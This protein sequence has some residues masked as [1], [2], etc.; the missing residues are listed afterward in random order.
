[1]TLFQILP[2]AAGCL[3]LI[4]TIWVLLKPAKD[5]RRG[6]A[7]PSLLFILFTGFSIYTVATDG[8][9]GFW[10]NHTVNA[11]GNQVWFD[12]LLAIGIAWTLILP[13]A[14]AQNMRLPLWLAFICCTG[15]VGV[16]AMLSR[17]FWLENEATS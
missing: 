2:I 17:L 1:M 7:I 5:G 15:C 12:L 10:N 4:I 11:S 14:R 3:F 16:L 9:I 8:L 6:W 13:R